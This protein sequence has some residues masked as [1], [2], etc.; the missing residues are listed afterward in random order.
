[1]A[2]H[3]PF[4]VT[5]HPYPSPVPGSTCAYELGNTS[6]RNAVLFIGGLGDGPHTI[7]YIRTVSKHLEESSSLDYSIFEIRIRSSFQGFGTS[8]LKNDVEDIS[9]L[10]RY[11][12][13]KGRQRIVLFGHSTGCQDCIEYANYEKNQTEPVDGFILQAPVSD[14]EFLV[15][16]EPNWKDC[17]EAAEQAIAEGKADWCL[18]PAK[19]PKA[20]GSYMT[21]YR[22]RSFL[23]RDG[24]DDYFSSDLSDDQVRKY[25]GRFK[26]PVLVAHSEKDEYVPGHVDQE[27]LSKRYREASPLVSP[28]SGLIPNTGHTVKHEEAR[29]WLAKRVGE[30]LESLP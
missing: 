9:A 24:D 21:A 8:S 30:F 19:V 10:V 15:A 7:P 5:V 17:L 22:L 13:G 25:W 27:A 18:P 6:A 26:S 16:Q 14:R 1:M 29:E 12:R 20:L 2:Q 4:P 28:L 23:A 3:N 11:L